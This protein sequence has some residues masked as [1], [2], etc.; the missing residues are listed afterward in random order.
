VRA[1]V[2]LIGALLL[3]QI[4]PPTHLQG[5]IYADGPQ[6]PA[7]AVTAAALEAPAWTAQFDPGTGAS[8]SASGSDAMVASPSLSGSARQFSMSFAKSGG[9]LFHMTFGKDTAATHF[10]YS[11]AV[12]LPASAELANLELDMN[13]VLA[14]GDTVIYGFQ[15][16]GY[17]STW[18]YS[19]NT[20]T[21]VK[22]AGT[23]KHSSQSCNPRKWT[24]NA[25]HQVTIAYT[26]DAAGDVT[27][28]AVW[29][30]GQ[31]QPI[32]ATAY[33]ARSL[34]WTLGTL[35]IN[36]QLDGLGASGSNVAYLDDVTVSRW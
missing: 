28:E 7:T 34:G 32:N 3:T 6:I 31:K 16:D 15:C 33:G 26:R 25:W 20:G 5:A 35:L 4:A 21:D 22:P 2:S 27:Y 24:L 14:D 10:V 13:Q 19:A 8:A 18:D 17:S 23:W 11:A 30:D 12:Y 29:L 36:F 9:E 1:L